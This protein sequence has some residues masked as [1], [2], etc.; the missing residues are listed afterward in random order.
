MPYQHCYV[1]QFSPL[2]HSVGK[3]E[4]SDLELLHVQQ[5]QQDAGHCGPASFFRAARETHGISL[6]EYL[7]ISQISKF[8]MLLYFVI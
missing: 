3:R 5:E 1:L 4:P 7:Q 6:E 8:Y 2:V